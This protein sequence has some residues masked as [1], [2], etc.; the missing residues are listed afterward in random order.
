MSS[1]FLFLK[2]SE[3]I[4]QL[5]LCKLGKE[6]SREDAD[7]KNGWPEYVLPLVHAYNCTRQSSTGYSP[8]LL[9]FGHTACLPIH[10]SLGVTFDNG[11]TQPYTLY[12][13]NL[14]S[15]LQYA[16]NLAVQNA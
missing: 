15:R 10:V 4:T 9:M 11:V 8:Y 2:S 13:E 12:A 6:M 14:H 16:H 3:C 5:T 7:E 1:L